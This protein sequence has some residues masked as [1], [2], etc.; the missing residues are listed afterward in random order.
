[1]VGMITSLLLGLNSYVYAEES[2]SNRN[3]QMVIDIATSP[4]KVF[5]NITNIKPGD[6]LTKELTI[7]N[8]GKQ[9]FN[10]ILTN[11][12]INGSE[13]FYNELL[14]TVNTGQ[15][16]LFEGKLKDFEKLGSRELSINDSED[17]T[18]RVEMPYELGNDYQGL[19]TEFE[20]KIY[21]EGTLGG[22]IPVNNKLPDTGS[23]MF[24]FMLIGATLVAGGGALYL[25]QL[26][27]R[28][29][30]LEKIL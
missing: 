24:N 9:D 10:Y 25:F 29:K 30:A 22:I 14:L 16:K 26:I 17:L 2:D 11:K 6:H 21:V 20:F 1:M 7:T 23:D 5:F 18:F 13:K 12:F 19:A 15:T 28:K 27:R 3:N 4:S 8:Q